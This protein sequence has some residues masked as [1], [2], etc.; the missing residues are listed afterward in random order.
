LRKLLKRVCAREG[1]VFDFTR[2]RAHSVRCAVAAELL[3]KRTKM[4]DP[5]DAYSLGLLHDTGEALLCTLFPE[6]ME[7][8]IWFDETDTRTEREVAAFGVDHGQVGQWILESC[9]IR[10]ELAL[11]VQ[12]HHDVMRINEPV[13][14]LL[15]VAN[16]VASAANSS[17]IAALD[18]LGSDRLAMLRLSRADLAYIHERVTERT[19][20]KLL[21]V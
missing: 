19:G 9:G 4:I 16:V 3:A 5:D 17:E 11:T 20:E 13:A 7:N 2:L 18:D 1:Q 6:E 15:H 21:S 12:T 10:R 14:L 8:I